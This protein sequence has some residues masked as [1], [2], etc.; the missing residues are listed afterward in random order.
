MKIENTSTKFKKSSSPEPT[1]LGTMHSRVKGFKFVQM[2]APSPFFSKGD[3][4]EIAKYIDEIKK[5]FSPEPPCQYAS[6]MKGIQ[7]CS[8]KGPRPFPMRDNFE[9]A[10]VH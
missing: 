6:L 2:T 5:Y 3:N 9:I 10:K 1:E 7:V 8:N 4:Y